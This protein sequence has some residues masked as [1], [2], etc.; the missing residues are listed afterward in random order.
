MEADTTGD[1]TIS[2]DEFDK[3]LERPEIIAHLNVLNLDVS[4]TRGL[5]QLVDI[6]DTGNVEIS[7]MVCNMMRLKGSARRV[8]IAT[9]M[10]ENKRIYSRL[11]GLF[12]HIE[13]LIAHVEERSSG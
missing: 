9:L 4:E 10:Y 5:F 6:D 8:D 3:H 12:Q 13:D 1:G 11:S 2:R 7:E